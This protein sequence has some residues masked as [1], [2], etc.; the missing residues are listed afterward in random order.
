MIAMDV[1]SATIRMH[2][3]LYHLSC[4]ALPL[5][6]ASHMSSIHLPDGMSSDVESVA[7]KVKQGILPD[8]DR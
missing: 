6:P 7:L 8:E 4:I 1:L 2:D 3:C 5:F